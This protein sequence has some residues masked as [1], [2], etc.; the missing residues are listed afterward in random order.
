MLLRTILSLILLAIPLL[1]QTAVPP[2]QLR[3]EAMPAGSIFVVLPSGLVAQATLGPGISITLDG[4]G[5]PIFS[6]TIPTPPPTQVEIVGERP[7][8]SGGSSTIFVLANAPLA[9]SLKVFRN[10]IRQ[11]V[12]QDYT[13]SGQTIT[14]VPALAG[15]ASPTVVC[16]YIK[17]P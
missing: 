17:A 7:A 15:D 16:D 11:Y 9:S 6:V 8:A 4:N 14:F 2:V 12:G 5:K 13:L 3:G 10:G 1:A